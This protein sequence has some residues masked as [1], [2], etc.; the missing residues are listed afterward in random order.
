LIRLRAEGIAVSIDDF[1]TGYSSLGYLRGL[2]VRTLKIDRSFV[3]DLVPHEDAAAI[4]AAIIAMARE[5]K[6]QVVAE[7]V[8]NKRQLDFL[9]LHRCDQ[10]QGFLISKPAPAAEI[11]GL[12]RGEDVL[13]WSLSPE[14]AGH[15]LTA[16][17][18]NSRDVA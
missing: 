11:E 15:L 16:E 4:C 17:G 1:G 8:E 7:G 2:P 5:L 18:L 10:A 12:L 6:M 14:K 13:R 3:K 9:T